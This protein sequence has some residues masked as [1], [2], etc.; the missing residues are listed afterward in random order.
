MIKEKEDKRN[1]WWE[2][3]SKWL[4]DISERWSVQ[5]KK[6]ILLIFLISGTVICVLIA[7]SSPSSKM[8]SHEVMQRPIIQDKDI[9]EQ[10]MEEWLEHYEDSLRRRQEQQIENDQKQDS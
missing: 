9:R 8:P 6:W 10:L 1:P 5:Q 3:R 2:R 7:W 4:R